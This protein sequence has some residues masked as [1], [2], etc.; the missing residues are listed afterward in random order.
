MHMLDQCRH[1]TNVFLQTN[2]IYVPCTMDDPKKSNINLKKQI[3]V[4][5]YLISWLFEHWMIDFGHGHDWLVKE[6]FLSRIMN[7][8]SQVLQRFR[9]FKCGHSITELISVYRFENTSILSSTV[10]QRAIL[11]IDH[12][13][14]L[15]YN[16]SFIY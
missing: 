8:N 1:Q 13:G 9:D 15:K 3:C 12:F 14:S 2:R 16:Q 11:P 5:K 6:S 10:R 7:Y 4:K